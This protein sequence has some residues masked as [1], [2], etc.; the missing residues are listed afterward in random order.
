MKKLGVFLLVCCALMTNA[1][2]ET[3]QYYSFHVNYWFN[4]HHFLKQ[5]SLLKSLD[6]TMVT[7]SLPLKD[8]RILE[9]GVKYYTDEFFEED[10]RTSDLFTD[11]KTWISTDPSLEDTPAQFSGIISI[12][13]KIDPVYRAHFWKNHLQTI[14][15]VLS[16]NLPMI[17]NI[18][19]QFVDDL[20]LLTRQFWPDDKVRVDL[21]YVAKSSK[22]NVRNRPYTSIFPTWVVMNAYGEN[23]VKGNWIELLFHESAHPMI[24]SRDYFVAGT[25]QDVARAEGLKLPRQ[26]WHA[27]LFYLT[28]DLAKRLLEEDIAYDTTYMQRNKVF[29]RYYPTLDKYLPLYIKGEKTLADVTKSIILELNQ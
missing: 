17:K 29:S 12:L 6:S 26:L 7:T 24:L 14:E 9:E 18:E 10:L 11:F 8:Q 3:T 5:E 22:W 21:V 25:I 13:K 15:S 1:Q 23:D 20:E 4:L 28:G 2:V 27:Y 16:E 19:S